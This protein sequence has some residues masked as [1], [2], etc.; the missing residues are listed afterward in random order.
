MFFPQVFDITWGQKTRNSLFRHV[1]ARTN[2][3]WDGHAAGD[4]YIKNTADLLKQTFRPEDMIARIGGDEFIV[5]LP[6]VDEETC[7]QALARLRDNMEQ[8][9]RSATQ[10][11][12]LA[13][14]FST[15]R[16]GNNID[17]VIA[18]ADHRM[19][20]EKARMKATQK[21]TD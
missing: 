17:A 7:A 4:L 20:Q 14:G 12:S 1:S 11:I 13:A 8:S 2:L 6:L 15:A 16:A 3:P 19:Y 10:P 21:A 18:K 9:N 5:M